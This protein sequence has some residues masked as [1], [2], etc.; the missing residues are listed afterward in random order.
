MS[1]MELFNL[2]RARLKKDLVSLINQLSHV[3]R[4]VI[5]L[6]YYEELSFQ[7]IGLVLRKT[8]SQIWTIYAD[9]I[10]ILLRLKFNPNAKI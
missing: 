3:E 1:Q 10:G 6:Y 9:A 2:S 4:L 7:E 5:S 8:E